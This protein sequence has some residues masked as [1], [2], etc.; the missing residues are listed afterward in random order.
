MQY[1]VSY[2]FGFPKFFGCFL[3][4]CILLVLSPVSVFSQ[5]NVSA[6]HALRHHHAAGHGDEGG[7][8]L[9]ASSFLDSHYMSEGRDSLNG[10]SLWSNHIEGLYENWAIGFRHGEGNGAPY[11]EYNASIESARQF[12][13][14][15][16][17]AGYTWLHYPEE[18]A[19]D[20]ESEVG[21]GVSLV[22][23]LPFGLTPSID[24]YYS[25]LSE[26]GFFEFSLTR[27]FELNDQSTLL[28]MIV[29]GYNEG[30]VGEGHRGANHFALVLE[31]S[32]SISENLELSG[33]IA[34]NIAV[35][36]NAVRFVEDELLRDLFYAGIG[37]SWTFR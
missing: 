27:E 19:D 23:P 7:L 2:K 36:A 8:T 28:P 32:H 13:P 37:V 22:D 4:S 21:A 30:Y 15:D 12:G 17:Y 33:Y 11:T 34:G 24:W 26:G 20:E 16:I 14:V 1:S 29:L 10:H 6:A 25:F 31:A 18:A 3:K 35:N 9:S 5:E